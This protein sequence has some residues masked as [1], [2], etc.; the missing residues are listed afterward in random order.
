MHALFVFPDS[1]FVS[2]GYDCDVNVWCN[3]THQLKNTY[4]VS[5]PC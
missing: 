2:A 4:K 5:N 1:M 3:N